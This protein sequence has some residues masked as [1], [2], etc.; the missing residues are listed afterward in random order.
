MNYF[1]WNY[2]IEK[3][4]DLK[5]SGFKTKDDAIIHWVEYGEKEKRPHKFLKND[6][7]FYIM[8]IQNLLCQ[9]VITK[10]EAWELLIKIIND[11]ENI[12]YTYFDWEYYLIEN[13]SLFSK[14]LL[15]E[16]EALEHWNKIGKYDN[17]FK[18]SKDY[19]ILEKITKDNFDWVYYISNNIDLIKSNIIT[20]DKAWDHW[21]NYGKYENRKY[22]CKFNQNITYETFDWEY[23]LEKNKDLINFTQEGAWQHWIYYGR[24]EDRTIRLYSNIEKEDKIDLNCLNNIEDNNNTEKNLTE[25]ASSSLLSDVNTKDNTEKNLTECASTNIINKLLIKNELLDETDVLNNL[26]INKEII[27][28]IINNLENE[29]KH[30]IEYYFNSEANAKENSMNISKLSIDKEIFSE[31]NI[32]ENPIS[33]KKKQKKNNKKNTFIDNIVNIEKFTI[34]EKNK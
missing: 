11:H 17:N 23:Y 31:E 5:R 32:K 18:Y 10:E 8:N 22:K 19:F 3:N 29:Y 13:D 16:E 4:S 24:N 26:V 12:P 28:K 20:L 27:L 21:C 6:T 14:V 33:N 34:T 1:D 2:Y 7:D 30:D 25:C 15:T 9:E